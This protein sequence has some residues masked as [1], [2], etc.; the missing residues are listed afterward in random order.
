MKDL[1]SAAQDLIDSD[2]SSAIDEASVFLYELFVKSPDWS[3]SHGEDIRRTVGPYPAS[4]ATR[5]CDIVKRIARSLPETS[6][7]G[8]VHGRGTDRERGLMDQ[9]FGCKIAFMFEDNLLPHGEV[10]SDSGSESDVVVKSKERDVVTMTILNEMSS[11]K[12]RSVQQHAKQHAYKYS[13]S[14]DSSKTSTSSV[15]GTSWLQQQCREC[16]VDGLSWQQLFAQLFDLLISQTPSIE[17]EVT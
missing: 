10:C 14:Q 9:E 7:E 4:V 11:Q 6:G 16:D 2:D 5:A 17:N 8:R 13:A 1:H 15:Y 12:P 3:R